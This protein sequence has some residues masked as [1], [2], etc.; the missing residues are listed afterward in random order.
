MLGAE[1]RSGEPG[2]GRHAGLDARR[3]SRLKDETGAGGVPS[4]SDT[5]LERAWPVREMFR[6]PL[7]C[8]AVGLVL[9]LLA[10]VVAGFLVVVFFFPVCLVVRFLV[11]AFFFGCRVA[12]FGNGSL[13]FFR[14]PG[15]RFFLVAVALLRR[16]RALAVVETPWTSLRRAL[17]EGLTIPFLERVT[18]AILTNVEFK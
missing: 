16:A 18:G 8:R 3:R 5:G 1:D 12:Y 4:G 15:A 17:S 10:V 9:A 13:N 7:L 6:D 2:I 14:R 11:A